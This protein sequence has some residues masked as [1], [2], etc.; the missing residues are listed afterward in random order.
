MIGFIAWNAYTRLYDV[1][2]T[3]RKPIGHDGSS[4]IVLSKTSHNG[5]IVTVCLFTLN[6]RNS[7]SSFFT[8]LFENTV[9]HNKIPKTA[10]V[11]LHA[12]FFQFFSKTTERFVHGVDGFVDSIWKIWTDLLDV[13]SIDCTFILNLL[14]IIIFSIIINS[15]NDCPF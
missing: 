13:M 1:V 8:S 4:Y 9:F 14:L 5:E 15:V 3:R 12:S 6:A 11:L 10:F 7:S 2:Y